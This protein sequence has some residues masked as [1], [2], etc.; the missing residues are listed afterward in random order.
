MNN[1]YRPSGSQSRDAE[2]ETTAYQIPEAD[3]LSMVAVQGTEDAWCCACGK[4]YVCKQNF[5]SPCSQFSSHH[6]K[7]VFPI[8]KKLNCQCT[9]LVYLMECN[10]CKQSYVG[11]TTSNLPKRFSNHKSHIKK[12]FRSCKLLNHFLDNIDHS[13]DFSKR[14]FF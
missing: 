13:L 1:K 3:P 5:L 7:Q 9:N 4:C 10:T 14:I 12:G 11:Y 8:L 2:R 6:S